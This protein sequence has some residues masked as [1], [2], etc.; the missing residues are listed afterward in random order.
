MA[1][2]S[3]R[4]DSAIIFGNNPVREALHA[5]PQ[6]I[7]CI[8]GVSSARAAMEIVESARERGIAVEMTDHATL[9][10]LTQGGHHQGIAARTRPFRCAALAEVL[11]RGAPLLVALD[12]ITDPQNLGSIIRSAEVLGAGGLI[13]PKDRSATLTPATIRASA[14]AALHLPVAQVVNLARGL[15]DAK[16]AGYWIVAMDVQGAQRF[17]DLPS[18]ERALIL[19]GS[20]GKGARRLVLEQADFRVSIPVRGQVSSLNAAV[21]AAI[22]IHE[23]SAILHRT[24]PPKAR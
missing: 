11:E 17:Q 12:G 24:G 23:L 13:L 1:R 7:L 18:L 15:K 5:R 6:E 8:L 4:P 16:E 2:H 22:G 14:G 21:A 19:I 9:D 20:E 10:R 3:E